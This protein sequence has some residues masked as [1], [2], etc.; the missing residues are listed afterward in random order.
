MKNLI[1]VDIGG[2]KIAIVKGNENGEILEKIRFENDLS[3]KKAIERILD[4]VEKMGS[5]DAIG[6][7]CG[8][9]LDTKRGLILSPPNLPGWDEVPIVSLLENA[10]GLPTFLQNDADACALAE[11]KHGA[12]RGCDSMIFLTFGTGL[13]AGLILDGR[14]YA[15]SS[16]AAGEIGHVAM[17]TDGPIGY[18]KRGSLEGFCS[19]GGIR[20]TSIAKAEAQ[21][22]KGC[23]PSFCE[24]PDR[25]ESITAKIVADCA[26]K[27]HE[28]ALEIYKECGYMLGRGLAILI[29]LL[30]P[31]RIVIGSIYTRSHALLED[32]MMQ[33][34]KKE[35]LPASLANCRIL[36]AALG[37][38]LGDI[39]ALSVAQNGLERRIGQ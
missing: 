17:E 27:G 16:G 22:A 33:A 9:P 13:G 12:G 6:I 39:A 29:D 36:P 2:T 3:P 10:T 14:L 23:I 25:L 19:G 35:A 7:S 38:A 30:N 1:G 37:E 21:F 8:G 34:L 18:G 31:Q 15:G 28:D 5:A 20:Q 26:N 4:S 24:S 32:S 11:W